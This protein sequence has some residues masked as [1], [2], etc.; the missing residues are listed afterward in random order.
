MF[1]PAS[2]MYRTASAVVNDAMKT[3]VN[4]LGEIIQAQLKKVADAGRFDLNIQFTE[5]CNQIEVMTVKDTVVVSG[6]PKRQQEALV[7]LFKPQLVAAGYKVRV[8][9]HHEDPTQKYS[10]TLYISFIP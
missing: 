6:V 1:K 3:R 5:V 7:A 2:E 8:E 4:E 9:R 10:V